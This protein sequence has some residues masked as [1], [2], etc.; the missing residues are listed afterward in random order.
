MSKAYDLT[1][2]GLFAHLQQLGHLRVKRWCFD[3]LEEQSGDP[4]PQPL[5]TGCL[6]RPSHQVHLPVNQIH[7]VPGQLTLVLLSNKNKN[8]RATNNNIYSYKIVL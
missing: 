6:N 2:A 4:L 1:P 3:V 8:D 5:Q 7:D